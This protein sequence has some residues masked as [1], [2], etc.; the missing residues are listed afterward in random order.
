MRHGWQPKSRFGTP[1]NNCWTM[2]GAKNGLCPPTPEAHC[3]GFRLEVTEPRCAAQAR[4]ERTTC[5][6]TPVN[7][8]EA[9][10]WSDALLLGNLFLRSASESVQ[11]NAT[12]TALRT[13]ARSM[14]QQWFRAGWA[15]VYSF[16]TEICCWQSNL[17][18][19]S[20]LR[21]GYLWDCLLLAALTHFDW[22]RT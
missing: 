13:A 15:R 20:D 7:G 17:R 10:S 2:H 12:R 8:L 16:L 18:N 6:C 22:P 19:I 4:K 9:T 21:L 14:I 5:K 11:G 1:R 3:H